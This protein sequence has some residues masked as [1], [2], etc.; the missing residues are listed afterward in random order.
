MNIT[1][2]NLSFSYKKNIKVVNG[3]SLT[4]YSGIYGLIGPNGAGKS[5]LI[6]LLTLSETAQT[7]TISYNDVDISTM[8]KKY[9]KELGYMPQSMVGFGKFKVIQ[10]LY[11]IATLKDMDK[12]AAKTQI[13]FLIVRLDLHEFL[14]KNMETLSGG[15]RQRVL[16]AQSI[17]DNPKILILDEP[18][19]G[20][21]PFQRI[22]LRNIIAEV[23]K[24]KIVIIATH[25]MQD[26]E[27]IAENILL[28]EK[29]KIVYSGSIQECLNS[30]KVNEEII[31]FSK[32][33]DYKTKY[34]ISRIYQ[35]G[36]DFRIRYI[37]NKGSIVPDLD[38]AYLHYLVDN[39]VEV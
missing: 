15:M 6:K 30:F 20:L 10:F 38:D 36:E 29:G 21:D 32:L 1:V 18:T 8:K 16:F 13:D 39:H 17:L 24:D 23:A 34:K 35:Y 2:Q 25:V 14:F 28:F 26:I 19:A 7:G 22:K 37:S 4:L 3:V 31:S 9:K 11:Y 27:A 33:D 5:T 12:I